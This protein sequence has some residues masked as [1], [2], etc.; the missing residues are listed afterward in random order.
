MIK[1]KRF[2][3]YRL[4]LK[5]IR[6]KL[7][8]WYSLAFISSFFYYQA[9]VGGLKL[10]S[11]KKTHYPHYL[12]FK[13][14]SINSREELLLC[15]FFCIFIGNLPTALVCEYLKNYSLQLCYNYSRKLAFSNSMRKLSFEVKER[16]K[17]LNDFLSEIELFIPLF[18]LVPN[19]I[20]VALTN[21]IFTLIFLGDLYPTVFSVYFF[22]FF[23]LV[24]AIS[25]FFAY[26]LQNKVNQNL[27]KFRYQENVAMEKYLE[28]QNKS[29]EVKNL[30]DSNFKKICLFLKKRTFAYLPS[31]IIPSLSILFC[32]FYSTY[33]GRKWKIKE[34]VEVGSIAASIQNVFWKIKEIIDNLPEV[35]KIR[36]YYKS[37]QKLLDK[38]KE[39][40]DQDNTQ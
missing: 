20:F 12:L 7:I 11:Y 39:C 19:R 9:T 34:F 15:S 38:S 36:V 30:I 21:I 29:Q 4:L 35:S 33:Y 25:S 27:N 28:D 37:L 8:V 18:I 26:Q 31:L 3:L 32:F 40:Q 5:K 1:K 16:R 23:S 10:W 6:S 17:I 22:I 2:S 13:T 24:I 14:I